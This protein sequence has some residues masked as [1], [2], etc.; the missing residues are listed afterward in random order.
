MNRC[1]PSNHS[2]MPGQGV[3]NVGRVG[4]SLELREV[5]KRYG[6]GEDRLVRA[7]DDISLTIEVG[8]FVAPPPACS[9]ENKILQP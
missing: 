3:E 8:A 6:I 1:E 9:P 4:A 7:A 2:R 5:R